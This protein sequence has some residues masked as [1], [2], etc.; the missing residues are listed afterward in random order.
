MAGEKE[1]K[2]RRHRNKKKKHVGMGGW[3][4]E[5]FASPVDDDLKCPVFLPALSPRPARDPRPPKLL[6]GAAGCWLH[7]PTIL[8]V[9]PSLTP[10]VC[11]DVLNDPQSV[12]REGHAV[13]NHDCLKACQSRCPICRGKVSSR[14]G[15]REKGRKGREGRRERE[16]GR[17]AWGRGGVEC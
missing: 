12:C 2:N 1:V 9:P 13:C 14:R 11:L 5:L 3:P 8:T 16:G 15:C 6:A 4:E 17:E 10:Q 7:P